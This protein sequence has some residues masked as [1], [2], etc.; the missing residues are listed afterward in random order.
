MSHVLL[1]VYV[2]ILDNFYFWKIPTDD[3]IEK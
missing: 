3:A 2:M 1:S